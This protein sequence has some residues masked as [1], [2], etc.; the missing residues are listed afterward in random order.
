MNKK[1]QVPMF[2]SESL[3]LFS[4]TPMV[5]RVEHFDPSRIVTASQQT[6]ADCGLPEEV[7]I[8]DISHDANS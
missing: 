8:K 7:T 1:R 5:G 4:G 6:I 3:P 2:E